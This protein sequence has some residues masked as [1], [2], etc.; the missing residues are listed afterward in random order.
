[1]GDKT[2]IGDNNLFLAYTH[3]A[4]N[5]EVGNNTIFSNNATIAGHVTVGDWAIISG[6]GAVHQYCRVGAH[7]IIGGCSKIVQDVPP[8]LVA[9]GNPAHLRGV[10]IEGLK[11][12]GFT[13]EQS[14][15]LRRAYRTLADKNTNVTQALEKIEADGELSPEVVQLIEFIRA[16]KR[17]IVRPEPLAI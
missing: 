4:H 14:K 17:G 6:F 11:R 9:D 3:V 1:V 8:Y 12:R 16:T 13:E 15:T 10:N 5:C 7:S 2:V